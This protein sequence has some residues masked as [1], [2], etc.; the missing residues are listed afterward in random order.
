[1]AATD[2]TRQSA[3]KHFADSRWPSEL[4]FEV[5]TTPRR[6]RRFAT[7]MIVFSS[8]ADAE[9]RAYIFFPRRHELAVDSPPRRSRGHAS[10]RARHVRREG[11]EEAAD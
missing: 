9:A 10:M 4:A 8:I 3:A 11:D 7:P 1:M 6:R 5:A 2:G